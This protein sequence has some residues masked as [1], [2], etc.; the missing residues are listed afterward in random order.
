M[1]LRRWAGAAALMMSAAAGFAFWPAPRL[2]PV[3]GA[4]LR[5]DDME[6]V[7]VGVAAPDFTLE[8]MDGR[9]VTLSSFKGQFVLLTFYRGHW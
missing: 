8:A 7:R 4:G 2:G 9:P 3:D 1:T 6:R 5:P